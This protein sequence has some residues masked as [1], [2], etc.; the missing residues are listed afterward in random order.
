MLNKYLYSCKVINVKLAI[1]FLSYLHLSTYTYPLYVC[2]EEDLLD[3]AAF[4]KPNSRL[5]MYTFV[6]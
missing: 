5:C 2:R 4:L 6:T 3:T 1:F